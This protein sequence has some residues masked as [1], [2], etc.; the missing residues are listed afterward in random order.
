[1]DQIIKGRCSDISSNGKGIVKKGKD[2]FYVEGLFPGETGEFEFCFLRGGIYHCKLSKLFRINKDRI[3]PKCNLCNECDGCQYQQIAYK[4]QLNYKRRRVVNAIEKSTKIKDVR[5][6]PVQGMANPYNY[7]NKITL[8]YGYDNEHNIIYGFY[9]E[10]LREILPIDICNVCNKNVFSIFEDIKTLCETYHVTCYSQEEETG[11]LRYVE[12]RNGYHTDEIMVVLVCTKLYFKDRKKFINDLVTMHPEITSVVVNE[13]FKSSNTVFGEK[14][15]AVFG[16]NFINDT[17]LDFNFN[18]TSRSY[19]EENIGQAEKLFNSALN[20][21]PVDKSKTVLDV[22]LTPSNIGLIIAKQAKKVISVGSNRPNFLEDIENAKKNHI[23]NID[24][25]NVDPARYLNQYFKDID[26]VVLSPTRKGTNQDFLYSLIDHKVVQIIYVS[27]DPEALS[28]D[29]EYLSPF[30][31]IRYVQP[32]DM[33]PMTCD[34]D[35]VVYLILKKA[36]E[37]ELH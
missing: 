33:S 34:V 8:M 20:F 17:I 10:N 24:F 4:A 26:I 36:L 13:N 25:L 1:M 9:K 32:V 23:E 3:N 2:T 15:K 16:K 6:N 27:N 12:I 30:Y 37:N 7:K 31:E 35:T 28:K 22:S 18:I 19:I 29:L 11:T 21:I 14:E 5:V